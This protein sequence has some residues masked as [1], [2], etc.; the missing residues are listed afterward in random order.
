ME[1]NRFFYRTLNKNY[2]GFSI[3]FVFDTLVA[4]QN[5]NNYTNSLAAN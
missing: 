1:T 5:K 3:Q 2:R 4:T